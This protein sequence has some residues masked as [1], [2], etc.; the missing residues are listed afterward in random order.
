MVWVD[1]SGE[2]RGAT[3][4]GGVEGGACD[5]KAARHVAD[6]NIDNAEIRRCQE[7]VERNKV[8]DFLF[9]LSLL[10]CSF[11]CT[12]SP[13]TNVFRTQHRDFSVYG[14]FVR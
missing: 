6:N 11:V 1:A 7:M 14:K 5:V 4:G 12:T 8:L 9:A 13:H 3:A 2:G 10:L